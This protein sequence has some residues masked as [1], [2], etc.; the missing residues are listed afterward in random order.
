[1]TPRPAHYPGIAPIDAFGNGC[2]RFAG[3]SHRGSILCLPSGIRAWRP[4][5]VEDLAPGDF[6]L[7]FAEADSFLFLLL[8]AGRRMIGPP[9]PVRQAFAEKAIALECMDTGATCRTYNV[10]IAEGRP[11][12]AAL[13]AVD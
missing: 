13:I 2:F 5:R 1:M 7:T 3:M 9:E 4:A 8:G 12:A 11:I 10:L 6:D